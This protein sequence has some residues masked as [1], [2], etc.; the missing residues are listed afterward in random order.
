MSCT[1]EVVSSVPI[2]SG[3]AA[4]AAV[5]AFRRPPPIEDRAVFCFPF[6]DC[7]A[8]ATPADDAYP[9]FVRRNCFLR[10]QQRMTQISRPV[11]GGPGNVR[12]AEAGRPPGSHRR[13]T[14]FNPRTDDAAVAQRQCAAL[15]WRRPGF[16]S[17]QPLHPCGPIGRGTTLRTSP[18]RVRV[19]PRVRTTPAKQNGICT[20]LV[21]RS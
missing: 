6:S 21:N 18:V 20:C 4:S 2:L 19:P 15:P 8:G 13:K 5:Y 9:E 12:E 16:D 14:G 10:T 7:S 3:G 17:P 11:F 1:Y